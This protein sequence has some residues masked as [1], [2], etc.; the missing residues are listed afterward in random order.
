MLFDQSLLLTGIALGGLSPFEDV[1][2]WKT[3]GFDAADELAEASAALSRS[4]SVKAF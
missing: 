3:Y 1:D 4:S 2:T